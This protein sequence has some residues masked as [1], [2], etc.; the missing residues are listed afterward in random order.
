MFHIMVDKGLHLLTVTMVEVVDVLVLRR[1]H[2]KFDTQV[3]PATVHPLHHLHEILSGDGGVSWWGDKRKKST[4]V[5]QWYLCNCSPKLKMTTNIYI[6]IGPT[7]RMYVCKQH[8]A[9]CS[10][11]QTCYCSLESLFLREYVRNN[12]SGCSTS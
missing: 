8:V 12:A 10:S 5:K 9:A 7:I 2:P 11:I 4:M 3:L 1:S 6:H